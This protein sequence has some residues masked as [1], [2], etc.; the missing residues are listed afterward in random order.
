M[1]PIL[2]F[3]DYIHQT[4]FP[5][6]SINRTRTFLYGIRFLLCLLCME[7]IL[8]FIYAVAICKAQPAWEVYSPFQLGMLGYFNLN[9]IWLKLL[10]PWRLFRLWALCD[11]TDPPENMLRCMSNNYSTFAF[12]RAW[13]RSYNRWVIRYIYI[14]LGG[15]SGSTTSS[16]SPLWGKARGIANLLVVFTFVAIWHD[17]Q[18]QLLIWSWLITLFVLPEAIAEF[19]F[20]KRKW[21]ARKDAYRII[22]AVGGVGNILMLI[23]ANLVGF[24][25]GWD[26]LKGLVKQLVGNWDGKFIMIIHLYACVLI[27]CEKQPL[28]LA[29]FVLAC[30][31][32]FVGVQVMFEIR[33]HEARHG[34]QLKC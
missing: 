11:G 8:H 32:L 25:V 22:C 34:I 3:N 1:G 29:F 21:A 26:G 16:S 9:I 18:L 6:E 2:T 19:L 14:P 30:C 24:A 13:H 23:V 28:G 7:L 15:S 27:A 4:R 20:P 10:L 33:E 31:A 5:L 12:W 17:I